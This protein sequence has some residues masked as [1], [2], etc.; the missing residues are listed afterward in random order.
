MKPQAK[1]ALSLVL[2]VGF[3]ATAGL[4]QAAPVTSNFSLGYSVSQSLWQGG[5]TAGIDEAH[6]TGGSVGLYY[7]IKANAGTVASSVNGTLRAQYEGQIAAGSAANI[8]FSFLP[9]SGSIESRF[10]AAASTG[11]F[12]DISGCIGVIVFGACG[13]IP[14]NID[15]DIPVIDEGLFLNP[16]ITSFTPSI[17]VTR[18]ANDADQAAGVGSVDLVIGN[19]GPSMNLDLDQ[20]IYLTP[21]GLNGVL[22]YR[23]LTSGA[24]GS[25]ALSIPTG[26]AVNLA[27]AGLDA[28]IWEFEVLNLGLANTFRNDIDLELRPAFDYIVG[29]WPPPGSGPFGFGLID[30]TFALGF[31]TIER[32][33]SFR[34]TAVADSAPD[35]NGVPEPGTL[36]LVGTALAGLAMRRRVR[37]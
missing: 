2:G 28:G 22:S 34:V 19:L 6:R 11:V 21:N 35:P 5:P 9:G 31:N 4:A 10:G 30:E 13:G 1:R 36:L 27:L 14:Y 7:D 18:S 37:K 23:N 3:A 32:V 12:L 26:A 25:M 20:T 8:A 17:D 16:K 24:S 33:G 15:T 29:S